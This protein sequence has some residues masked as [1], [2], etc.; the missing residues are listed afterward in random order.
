MS[1]FGKLIDRVVLDFA[2]KAGV[3]R[4]R[5]RI[6]GNH[7]MN[8]DA[9]SKGRR[10]YGWKAPSTDGDAA[11]MASRAQLRQLSRDMMRNRPYALRA[12]EVVV[13]NVVGTGIAFSV[14]HKTQETRDKIEAKLRAH[15][16]SPA[17]DARGEYD[18]ME[19]QVVAM[20]AV[21]TDGEVLAR[22]RI[23]TGQ[24]ARALPLG[25]Q[26]ELI[27]ADYLDLSKVSNG[28]NPVIE[29]VEYGPIGDVQAYWLYKEHPG[30][31][32]LNTTMESERVVWQDIIHLRR[33][34]RPGQLRGVPWLAP[35]MLTM[36]E[37]SDYQEAQILKQRM[38]ALLAGV[39][40]NDD[41]QGQNPSN[42]T[43]GLEDLEPGA[44]VSAP[45][46]STVTFTT[47]PRVDGYGEFMREGLGAIAMGIGITR[48]SLTGDL[49]GV[50][51]SSGRMG[52]MEM[53]RNVEGWQE[54]LMIGQFCRGIGRW[55]ADAWKLISEAELAREVFAIDWTAPRRPLID[56]NDEIDAEIKA[57]DAGI[58][59]RQGVQRKLGVDP[60]RVRRERADDVQK[61]ADAKL[62]TAA[63]T[64]PKTAAETRKAKAATPA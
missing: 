53:D 27:E 38:A 46:G 16:M 17:I 64:P 18:L 42:S 19:M 43:K 23:R 10:T 60:D 58:K 59:S 61:D 26:V 57:I 11:A 44:L 30:S 39:I 14:D 35:V 6:A 29:G 28:A 3:A 21:F 2:P 12:R 15:L 49:S 25:F 22:R 4:M 13:T 5:A 24:Y 54:H 52:R 55:V 47:P 1:A 7:L 62:T 37:L 45:A 40:T 20:R 36:G 41:A 33:F 50:N 9:A 31:A 8:Y 63:V 56:P 48:E 32:R 51:F 34:D